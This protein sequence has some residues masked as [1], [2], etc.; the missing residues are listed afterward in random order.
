MHDEVLTPVIFSF[1]LV[2]ARVSSIF[3]FLPIPMMRQA[4]EVPKI[5]LALTLSCALFPFW[6]KIL[7]ANP[8][9]GTVIFWIFREASIGLAIGLTVSFV[10][11]GLAI[12]T[13][14]ISAQAGYSYA[15]SVDPSSNAD[16]GVLPVLGQLMASM[17]FFAL[18]FDRQ[19]IGALATSLTILPPGSMAWKID[20]FSAEAILKLSSGMFSTALRL[21]LPVAGLLIILDLSLALLSRVNQQ[22]QLL[23]VAFPAKMLLALAMLAVLTPVIAL[24]YESQGMQAFAALRQLMR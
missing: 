23:T 6:P 11:E 17:L 24:V 15:T 20:A 5:V 21:A 8:A 4:P 18:G 10:S 2:L 22:L 9:I 3:V 14:M 13:Q 12:A 16:S 19:I 7:E 1:L